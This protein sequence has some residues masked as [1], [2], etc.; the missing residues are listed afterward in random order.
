MDCPSPRRGTR[1]ALKAGSASSLQYLHHLVSLLYLIRIS[2]RC[3]AYDFDWLASIIVV[4]PHATNNATPMLPW[5]L[6]SCLTTLSSSML[7]TGTVA[8]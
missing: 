4:C 3:V 1:D 8:A 2:I 5:S 7:T 6:A